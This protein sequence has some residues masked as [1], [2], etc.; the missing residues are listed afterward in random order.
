MGHSERD[1]RMRAFCPMQEPPPPDPL[2][3][4]CVDIMLKVRRPSAE[5]HALPDTGRR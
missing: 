4:V 1:M 3:E 5:R 2:P